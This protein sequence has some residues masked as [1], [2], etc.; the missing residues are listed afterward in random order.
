MTALWV[1]VAG[2]L[3]SLARYLVGATATRYIGLRMPWGPLIVNLLGSMA[4]GFVYALYSSRGELDS[5]T[6]IAITTGLLGGFTTYSAFAYESLQLLEKR[7][8]GLF[9]VY[10]GSTLVFALLGC[11][12]GVALGKAAAAR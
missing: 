12:A 5:R 4:I 10:V 6:R 2:G 11:A 8:P 9:I 7:S 3:G 1:M